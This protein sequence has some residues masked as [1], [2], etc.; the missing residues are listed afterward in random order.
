MAT[1]NEA[2]LFNDTQ[3]SGDSCDTLYF[4][5]FN[6][7]IN[8]DDDTS[9]LLQLYTHGKRLSGGTAILGCFQ[10]GLTLIL[11]SAVVLFILTRRKL[12]RQISKKLFLNMQGINIALNVIV[13][14]SVFYLSQKTERV[15]TNALLLTKFFS[16]MSTTCDRYMCIAYPYKYIQV[17]NRSVILIILLFWLPGV[18]FSA[19]GISSGTVT[20]DDLC[21]TQI[22][23]FAAASVLLISSNISIYT[24]AKR[25]SK[26]EKSNEGKKIL[27]AT[28]ICV[29]VVLCFVL[30][31]LPFAVHNILVVMA[32]YQPRNDK[33]FTL[34][35]LQ[36]GLLHAM[37]E[38]IL[39]FG[40]QRDAKGELKKSLNVSRNTES[41]HQNQ[42]EEANM[43]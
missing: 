18:I 3:C 11:N 34:L 28:Y 10:A 39:F 4:D 17:T 12:R 35:V 1:V 22:V 41:G 25:H 16:L 9:L 13:I 42:Q 43:L 40:F 29:S 2:V 23:V 8:I 24:I 21:I 31:W 19:V 37:L 36:F 33:M 26:R 27:K 15:I 20:D 6:N 5:D 30:L 7:T 38:P 14:T 32:L